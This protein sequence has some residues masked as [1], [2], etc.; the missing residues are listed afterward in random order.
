VHGTD[1]TEKADQYAISH[2]ITFSQL[3]TDALERLIKKKSARSP[4]KTSQPDPAAS[5][6]ESQNRHL[7]LLPSLIR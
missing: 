7:V 3:A 2:G 5:A 6:E 1:L 4:P